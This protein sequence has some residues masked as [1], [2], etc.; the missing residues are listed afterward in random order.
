MAGYSVT[1]KVDSSGVGHA[2]V[3]LSAPGQADIVAGYYPGVSSPVAP[4]IV[5]N[6]AQTGSDVNGNPVEHLHDWS[7][8]AI[9]L[10]QAQY[11]AM[12]NYVIDAANNPLDVYLLI[13]N[14][15]TDFVEAVLLAGGIKHWWGDAFDPR[16]LKWQPAPWMPPNQGWPNSLFHSFNDAEGAFAFR[17]DGWREVFDDSGSL[18]ADFQTPIV[19]DLD[20]DG[21]DTIAR[22]SNVYFDHNG[23]GLAEQTGWVAPDD[24]LLV[25]DRNSSGFIESGLELFG[26]N[27][28]LSDGTKAEDGYQALSELDTNSDGKVDVND[29]SWS[30]LNV[31]RDLDGN[32]FSHQT[33]FLVL[34][35]LAFSQLV[36]ITPTI[37][38]PILKG[39]Y[40]DKPVPLP[41]RME[42]PERP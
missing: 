9:N 5:K 11:D 40:E 15:C 36:L 8:G 13:G 30:Q 23:D 14:N 17:R 21:I 12:K 26:N 1:V 28:R 4:G 7:S 2:Y 31:W 34:R 42:Q 32:G 24:G 38:R 41:R 25:R 22:N 35:T 16:A 18:A 20:G 10:S 37:R 29:E 6:D 3:V 27:T 19:L 39:I 33:N